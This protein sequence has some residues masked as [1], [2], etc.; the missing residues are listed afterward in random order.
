MPGREPTADWEVGAGREG[1]PGSL[2]LLL[3][4]VS[5]LEETLLMP[6]AALEPAAF[7]LVVMV[8]S[9]DF[10]AAASFFFHSS[11]SSLVNDTSPPISSFFLP[12][13]PSA[14]FCMIRSTNGLT[15]FTSFPRFGSQYRSSEALTLASIRN[16][17]LLPTPMTTTISRL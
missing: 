1:R 14:R 9:L 6:A 4:A 2:L 7:L 13:K 15:H 11:S 10:L 3:L 8:C 17:V 5:V 16:V 12:L